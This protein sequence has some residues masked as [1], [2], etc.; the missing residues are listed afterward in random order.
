MPCAQ[1][2]KWRRGGRPESP[3]LQLQCRA[4]RAYV[5][6][7]AMHGMHARATHAAGDT[8]HA[9]GAPGRHI[10]R[11]PGPHRNTWP[12]RRDV[13]DA[14]ATRPARVPRRATA[15]FSVPGRRRRTARAPCSFEFAHRVL[16]AYSFLPAEGGL[17][18]QLN[19]MGV[20]LLLTNVRSSST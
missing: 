16:S 13:A 15:C 3:E 2:R 18:Q 10:D 14:P 8:S 6:D 20:M 17:H 9:P 4:A 12:P 19:L 5:G 1:Q 11:V 7:G